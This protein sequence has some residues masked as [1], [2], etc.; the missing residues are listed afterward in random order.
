MSLHKIRIEFH[1]PS[2]TKGRCAWRISVC[3]RESSGNFRSFT[4]NARS[5]SQCNFTQW[6][7][8]WKQSIRLSFLDVFTAG[9]CCNLGKYGF[10]KQPLLQNCISHS[11]TQY[12]YPCTRIFTVE[13]AIM[14]ES[15]ICCPLPFCRSHKVVAGFVRT[16]FNPGANTMCKV[17]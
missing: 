17:W 5:H 8:K 1:Q 4:K 9:L 3:Q 13:D 15:V 16:D 10:E 2:N 14:E 12:A 11:I 7:W 6:M